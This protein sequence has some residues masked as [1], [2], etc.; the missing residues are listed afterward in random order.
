MIAEQQ[1]LTNYVMYWM[2]GSNISNS[3]SSIDKKNGSIKLCKNLKTKKKTNFIASIERIWWQFWVC[4][5]RHTQRS[6]CWTLIILVNAIG[7]F[8]LYKVNSMW[9]KAKRKK[10]IYGK[11]S[12]WNVAKMIHR[13]RIIY[14][15][16]SN[17]IMI[18]TKWDK[19]SNMYRRKLFLSRSFHFSIE[20]YKNSIVNGWCWSLQC[21]NGRANGKQV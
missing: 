4:S 11:N 12:S 8:K 18:W 2:Q 20:K 21:T 1:S 7:K 6:S 14:L 10:N 19:Y 3:S 15:V 13:K 17:A 9:K 16:H 5:A